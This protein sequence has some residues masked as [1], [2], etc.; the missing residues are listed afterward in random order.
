MSFVFVGERKREKFSR[1][2]SGRKREKCYLNA[3]ARERKMMKKIKR[4]GERPREKVLRNVRLLLWTY[5]TI[6]CIVT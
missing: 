5:S 4:G 6:Q 1:N 2:I 3:C